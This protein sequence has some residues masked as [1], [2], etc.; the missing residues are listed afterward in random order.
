MI[1]LGNWRERPSDFIVKFDGVWTRMDL[2]RAKRLLEFEFREY[3]QNLIA[4]MGPKAM[5]EAY[6]T[7]DP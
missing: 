7:Q 6:A 1:E 4:T 2:N 5:G 3:Q